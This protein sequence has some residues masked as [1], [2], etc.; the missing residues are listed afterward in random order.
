MN[1]RRL[2]ELCDVIVP[3]RDKPK[4]FVTEE[5]GIPWCRIEDIEGKF[6]N[7]SKSEKY[8]SKECIERM[9]LKVF[10]VGTVL[11][12]VTGASIGTYAITTRELITNQTFAGLVCKEN[13]LYNEFLYYY[14][15]MHTSTFINNSVGCAQA[16]ITRE[17]LENFLIP[18][19]EYDEQVRLVEVLK[20]LD[21][22]IKINNESNVELELMTRTIY[23]YWFLQFDFPDENEKPYKSS[24]GKMV[25]NEELKREIPEGWKRKIIGEIVSFENGDRGKNYPSGEDFKREGIPFI[26]GS[27]INSNRILYNELQYINEEKYNQLRAGKAGKGDILLTLRGSLAKCSYNPFE[28]AAIAS[29]LVIARPKKEINNTFLYYLLN[30]DYLKRLYKNY[31]NGSIQANL[32]VDT[33]KSFDCIVPTTEVLILWNE[34]IGEIDK[35]I[36]YL[37]QENQELVSLR[38]FLLPLLMNGQVGFREC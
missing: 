18:D 1:K 20:H 25:W 5:N 37:Q 12:A 27:M 2:V 24:G 9:N 32:S 38:D 23:D 11:C 21:D 33:L 29:A 16:Y 10:P 14:I 34:I 35:K 17:T 22:K 30:S 15:K 13:L 8:V 4:E 6:L 26:N 19:L 3:M 28:R 31:D 7:G 36:S